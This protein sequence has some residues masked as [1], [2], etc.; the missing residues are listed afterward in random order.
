MSVQEER[1]GGV[2]ITNREI[3]D[4]LLENTRVT[5]DLHH[6]VEALEKRDS[7][8]EMRVRALEQA[9]WTLGGIVAFLAWGGAAVISVLT[10]T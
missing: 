7:D 6:K 3:Y 8:Q 1:R 5:R 2:T 10:G 4:L 9:R